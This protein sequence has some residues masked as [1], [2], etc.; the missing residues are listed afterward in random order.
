[1]AVP[2]LKPRKFDIA[3]SN[4]IDISIEFEKKVCGEIGRAA[5]PLPAGR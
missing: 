1:M 5:H 4:L 3:Q 2:S